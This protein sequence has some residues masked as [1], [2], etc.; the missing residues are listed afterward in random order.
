MPF[1]KHVRFPRRPKDKSSFIVKIYLGSTKLVQRHFGGQ[2]KVDGFWDA[3]RRTIWIKNDVP[4]E[5]QLQVYEHELDHAWNDWRVW[6]MEK[7]RE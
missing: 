4:Y 3:N 2:M 6:H 5:L 7:V 1:P